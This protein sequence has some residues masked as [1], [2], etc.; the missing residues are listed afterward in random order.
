MAWATGP[1]AMANLIT[2][3]ADGTQH[4]PSGHEIAALTSDVHVPRL[5]REGR[6]AGGLGHGL[7]RAERRAEGGGRLRGRHRR[8][9]RDGAGVAAPG[10]ARG[11]RRVC[12]RVG[13]LQVRE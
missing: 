10:T 7:V 3:V 9:A 4:L 13:R 5:G 6:L 2:A 12:Q 8:R 1:V 11:Q